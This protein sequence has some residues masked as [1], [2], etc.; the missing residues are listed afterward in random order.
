[1]RMIKSLNYVPFVMTKDFVKAVVWINR[2]I[3]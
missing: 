3:V 2:R 1:M